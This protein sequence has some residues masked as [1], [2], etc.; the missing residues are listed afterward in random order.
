METVSLHLY[1]CLLNNKL[2][3]CSRV[4]PARIDGKG[5]EIIAAEIHEELPV[6][7]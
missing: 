5:A 6:Q 3:I 4:F 7:D 1:E 2:L